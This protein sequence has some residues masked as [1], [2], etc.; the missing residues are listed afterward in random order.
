MSPENR[1]RRGSRRQLGSAIDQAS[2]AF[3]VSVARRRY[4]LAGIVD[5]PRGRRA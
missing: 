1:G 4:P 5:F 2:R 3:A